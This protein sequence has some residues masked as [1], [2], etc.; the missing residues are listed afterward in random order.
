MLKINKIEKTKVALWYARISTNEDMQKHSLHAQ[1]EDIKK[2]C[3]L[4]WL[5]L[6]KIE[7]E[8]KS[9]TKMDKREK[10]Q[11][12]LNNNNFDVII[13]TKIDRLARNIVDLN[14]IVY[15]LKERWKDVVFIE[16]NIDTTSANGRLFLNILWAFAEFEAEII[17]ERVKRWMLE[18]KKRGVKL[19]RKPKKETLLKIEIQT[20]R[21][22]R[23]RKK[24]T[25]KEISKRLWYANGSVI[26][27]KL[28]N[29]LKTKE[30]KDAVINKN[31]KISQSLKKQ[32]TSKYVKW[33]I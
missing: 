22:L 19:W 3:E 15:S 30:H 13:T 14:K 4:Y 18:A 11:K 20:I 27:N 6:K 10:L 32:K 16:N 9:W 21:S 24:L 12:I 31:L 26:R 1:S 5:K 7:T 28:K 2:Y 17:S 29:Y 23:Q 8:K 25:Y 33:L